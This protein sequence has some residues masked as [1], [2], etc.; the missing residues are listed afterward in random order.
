YDIVPPEGMKLWFTLRWKTVGDDGEPV[1]HHLPVE[2]LIYDGIEEAALTGADWIYL[3]GKTGPLYRGE[4]PVYLADYD[5]NYI[6]IVYK[7][8]DIHIVTMRHE[9][10]HDDQNFWPNRNV[11][12]PETPVELV[13]HATESPLH[14]ERGKASGADS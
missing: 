8:P 9:R 7:S 4:P 3:G 14:A 11:P 2:D 10:G 6:S 13:I 12:P 5:G 1:E